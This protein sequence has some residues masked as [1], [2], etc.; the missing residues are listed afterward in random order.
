MR[1]AFT[2]PC[3]NEFAVEFPRSVRMVNAELLRE[4]IIGPLPLGVYYP[5]LT[6][7][8]LVCV[9]ETISRAEIER[10]AETLTRILARPL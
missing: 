7:R 2:G 8:G 3:F 4:K 1:L 9:T 10:F 5:E 6:K